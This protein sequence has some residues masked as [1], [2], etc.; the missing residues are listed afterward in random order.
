MYEK[1]LE[2]TG[3]NYY[4]LKTIINNKV[5][6]VK[7]DMIEFLGKLISLLT[8]GLILALFFSLALIAGFVAFTMYMNQVLESSYMG[9]MVS[10]SALTFIAFIIYIFRQSLI[11]KPLK[12][13][14]YQ[15]LY[16]SND[17]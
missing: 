4:F 11:Y 5:D 6:L 13:I 14:I 8:I 16:E 2:K 10:A 1:Q 17:E 15:N 3:E 12:E 7:L 9:S